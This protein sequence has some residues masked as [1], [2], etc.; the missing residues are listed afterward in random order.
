MEDDVINL[1]DT[2]EYLNENAA[3][4]DIVS[5]L[6]HPGLRN[7]ESLNRRVW[8]YLTVNLK[9]KLDETKVPQ[10]TTA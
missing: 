4:N 3:F 10:T 7:K 2:R 6:S 1:E 9:S 8:Y 5:I